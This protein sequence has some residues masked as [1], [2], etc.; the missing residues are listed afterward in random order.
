MHWSWGLGRLRLAE[1][2]GLD[3]RGRRGHLG[4]GGGFLRG[5][6]GQSG[7]IEKVEVVSQQG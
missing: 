6:A 2:M 7:R 1:V 4:K 3:G 5:I